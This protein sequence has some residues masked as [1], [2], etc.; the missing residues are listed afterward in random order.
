MNFYK[1]MKTLRIPHIDLSTKYKTKV[2]ANEVKIVPI[3]LQSQTQ[4]HNNVS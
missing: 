2:N 4:T 3:Q 1:P